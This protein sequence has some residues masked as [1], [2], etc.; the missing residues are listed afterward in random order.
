MV[1]FHPRERLFAELRRH[2]EQVIAS[3]SGRMLAVRG[4]RQVG[5]S[6]AVER[7]A[8]ASQ[9]PYVFVSGVRRASAGFQLE[10]AD[11]ALL[12]SRPSIRDAEV[13]ASSRS[14]SW[15]DWL[16]KI[17]LAARTGPVIVVLDELPWIAESDP[18][19]EGLL[20]AQWDRILEK[21]P[22]LLILIGSDVAM[23]ES[24][25]EHGRPLYGRVR[26]LVVPA[27]NP[28]EVANALP[29]RSAFESFDAYLVTG[30]Y[31]RLVTDLAIA[32]S[33][34]E[35]VHESLS[36]EFSPLVTNGQLTLDAEFPEGRAAYQVLSA[37]GADDTA[38]PNF[39]AVATAL[40]EPGGKAEQTA[41]T[42][43]LATLTQRGLVERELPA[44]AAPSS[45]L[46]RYRVTDPYLR[47][48]FRYVERSA[49]QAARGRADLAIAAFDRDWSSWR[50]R[51]IEPVV[52]QALDSLAAHDDRLAPVERVR[53]WWTRDGSHEVDVVAM[54]TDR[55]V[56][57]GTIK[58]RERGGV[59]DRDITALAPARALVPRS[60]QARL[61][62]ISPSG[63]A[64][65]SADASFSAVDLLAAWR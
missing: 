62:A 23:M 7:F 65:A 50:G 8:E 44:W 14:G 52:R 11:R 32:G 46:R 24:L 39:T 9:V 35:F 18:A 48:W 30:G 5:K 42:R 33:V 29:G 19:L 53:R 27:L 45:R 49:E 13:L 22:V 1:E 2:L 64:P 3:G 40:G 31:P 28:A 34:K 21:L 38:S 36:D 57:L 20:Q 25:V 37:I 54:A 41:A 51:S 4:R 56:L 15:Q 63:E 10:L 26:Q 59:S 17:A 55:T 12:E 16:G 47:F 60:A 6:T 43:A 61:V 58:W